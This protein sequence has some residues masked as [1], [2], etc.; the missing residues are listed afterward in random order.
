MK[1]LDVE[2]I[3]LTETDSPSIVE[4]VWV[5]AESQSGYSRVD[6][7]RRTGMINLDAGY[8]AGETDDWIILAQERYEYSE[9]EVAGYRRT[10]GIPKVLIKTITYLLPVPSVT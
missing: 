10:I 5:D 1:P 6:E 3:T 4:V 2:K 8:L 7:V 9:N